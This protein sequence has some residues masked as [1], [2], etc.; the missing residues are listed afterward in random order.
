MSP[1]NV[2]WIMTD[3]FNANCMSFL[4]SQCRTPNLDR[5]AD[6]GVCFERAYANNHICAPSRACFWS[7]QYLHTHG[8]Q[9]NYTTLY[10]ENNPDAMPALFRRNGYRTALV[11]KAHMPRLWSEEGF[12]RR[13]YTDLIDA[14]PSDPTTCHYFQY[15]DERGLAGWYEEGSARPGAPRPD[16]GSQPSHLPYEHSIEHFTGEQTLQFLEDGRDDDRPFFI[17]MSFQR[18]H[19]PIRPAPEHFGLYDPNEIELPASAADWFERGFATKPEFMQKALEGG[20]GYPLADSNPGPLRRVLASYYA[21]I[22]CIDMEIGRV[23][24]WLRENGEYDNTIVVFTADHGDFAGEH[25]LFHKNFG[26]YESIHR[27]PFLL[28]MPDGPTGER[29]E[30]IIESIDMYPTLCELAGLNTPDAVEGESLVPVLRDEGG[31]KSEALCEWSWGGPVSR[32]NALRTDRYRL[33]YY[34]HEIGGELY[35][36]Q[37]DS[38][39]MVNR[40][41]DPDYEDVRREL[42]ERLFDRV[43]EYRATLEMSDDGKLRRRHRYQ[44]SRLVQFGCVDWEEFKEVCE[45]NAPAR[46]PFKEE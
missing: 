2:L 38:G 40:W 42:T 31:G 10:P 24:D 28:R 7:G 3:Q 6:E 34:S 9:G 21:L 39:E 25:G 12:E 46:P 37:D 8:L 43:N 11:G 26:I 14:L 22:Y 45:K 5:L 16:D 18:P 41:G 4:G 35:D 17:H 19:G 36:H 30:G 33:V 44:P 27:I 32:I 23:L 29:R 1:P 13:R 15:L 20:C